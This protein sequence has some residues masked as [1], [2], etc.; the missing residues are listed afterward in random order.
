MY[1]YNET[2]VGFEEKKKTSLTCNPRSIALNVARLISRAKVDA[3]INI[4]TKALRIV[5][6]IHT[7]REASRAL[8]FFR[9]FPAAAHSPRDGLFSP[10]FARLVCGET[11]GISR[12]NFNLI[13]PLEGEGLFSAGILFFSSLKLLREKV[14]RCNKLLYSQ[15]RVIVQYGELPT[16]FIK[17]SP[18]KLFSCIYFH[19][20]LD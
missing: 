14:F 18:Y 5:Y 4:S 11:T 9:V 19:T 12:H 7:E 10:F 15:R 6:H 13:R 3:C 17:R 8:F 1:V 20:I 16:K 2:K